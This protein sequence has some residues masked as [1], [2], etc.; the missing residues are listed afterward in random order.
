[1]LKKILILILLPF[2]ISFAQMQMPQN[3]KKGSNDNYILRD[4]TKTLGFGVDTEEYGFKQENGEMKVRHRTGEWYAI[5]D[6]GRS[7]NNSFYSVD[8]NG[9]DEYA[10]RAYAASDSF[11][12][13]NGYER[14]QNTN[15][16]DFESTVGSWVNKGNHSID[17]NTANKIYGVKSG[18]I[19][20]TGAGDS[21]ANFVG[22]VASTTGYHGVTANNKYTFEFWHKSLFANAGDSVIVYHGG[23]RKAYACSTVAQKGVFNYTATSYTVLHDTIKIYSNVAIGDTVITDSVN[24]SQAY[25]IV[26][27]QWIYGRL[28]P[29]GLYP[30]PFIMNGTKGVFD[31]FSNP[32]TTT[33]T[34]EFGDGVTTKTANIA[35]NP[36]I[37]WHL[38]TIV[39]RREDSLFTYFDG[40]YVART[41]TSG[42]GRVT[43]PTLYLGRYPLT[44][45]YN[46]LIGETRLTRFDNISSSSWTTAKP[47]ATYNAYTLGNG[48]VDDITG[49]GKKIVVWY[50]WLDATS[51]A[52]FLH[53][54]SGNNYNL[55]GSGVTTAD[56]SRFKR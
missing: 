10:Y 20:S 37:N 23:L 25:D 9:A 40:V 54:L 3:I 28:T 31:Y 26:L 17:T 5:P 2:L 53:D 24:L 7:V 44:H 36:S 29:A 39:L 45:Y 21:L 48:F 49:G 14:F 38:V 1:M 11:L 13:M 27:S 4:T 15:S 12:N 18:Q 51:D 50:D 47:L 16:R 56:Q 6:S 30:S 52:N 55:T 22:I 35:S 19:I 34:A 8:L 41:L 33:L 46:G 32:S 43:N 42:V